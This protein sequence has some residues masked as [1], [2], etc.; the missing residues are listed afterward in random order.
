M[1]LV[2]LSAES[3][4]GNNVESLVRSYLETQNVLFN[5]RRDLVILLFEKAGIQ[6]Y[7]QFYQIRNYIRHAYTANF[8]RTTLYKEIIPS[9]KFVYYDKQFT[10]DQM[11][12]DE[13][14]HLLKIQRKKKKMAGT[15]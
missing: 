4:V 3:N 14:C 5:Q 11:F 12:F 2:A 13:G 15:K 8:S 1:A 6:T 10:N 9:D 7:E